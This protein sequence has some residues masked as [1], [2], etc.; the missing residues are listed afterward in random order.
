[1]DRKCSQLSV[2]KH[3]QNSVTLS[4]KTLNSHGNK[5][6]TGKLEV[7]LKK[8]ELCSCAKKSL[9][10]GLSTKKKILK[11]C[12]LV[13]KESGHPKS[14]LIKYLLVGEESDN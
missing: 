10:T 8:P 1:M 11:L 14:I 12:F 9:Q 5:K 6:H 2:E 7:C 4:A 3:F 13:L